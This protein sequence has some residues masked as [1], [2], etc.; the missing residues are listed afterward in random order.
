VIALAKNE[1]KIEKVLGQVRVL[2]DPIVCATL[3][4]AGIQE[5]S[6]GLLDF[7]LGPIS[8]GPE[9]LEAVA[10]CPNDD[11]QQDI[12]R[13]VDEVNT[14]EVID[15][16]AKENM[17]R[18][19]QIR[20]ILQQNLA[21]QI[22]GDMMRTA[23]ADSSSFL[24]IIDIYLHHENVSFQPTEDVM[25]SMISAV[26]GQYLAGMFLQYSLAF[27]I[28]KLIIRRGIT[29]RFVDGRVLLILIRHNPVFLATEKLLEFAIDNFAR[30]EIIANLIKNVGL[31]GELWLR[32]S[33]HSTYGFFPMTLTACED[34]EVTFTLLNEIIQVLEP[35]T[36]EGNIMIRLFGTSRSAKEERRNF[37]L[38]LL[39]TATTYTR[40]SPEPFWK[41]TTMIKSKGSLPCG[42]E[43]GVKALKF[44]LS[45]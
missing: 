7:R 40:K 44:V 20:T 45:S 38:A 19:S 41:N 39:S 30:P 42:A 36:S 11:L 31:T 14:R 32:A 2:T 25:F 13:R 10:A 15:Y 22:T 1:A 34:F 37:P 27:R 26:G 35:G 43:T 16:M 23:L 6:L 33:R 8:I 9:V 4:N 29:D 3:R 28:T 18:V 5:R 21:V 24:R 17:A 12:L